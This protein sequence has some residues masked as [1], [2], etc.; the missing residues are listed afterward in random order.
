M[1]PDPNIDSILSQT[2]MIA[3]NPSEKTGEGGIN[4]KILSGETFNNKCIV[5]SGQDNQ[6]FDDEG[7]LSESSAESGVHVPQQIV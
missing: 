2:E 4:I 7:I 6:N 1:G 5:S 3:V